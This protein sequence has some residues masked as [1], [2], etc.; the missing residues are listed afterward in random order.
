[1]ALDDTTAAARSEQVALWRA[2]GDTEKLLAFRDLCA[3]V[4]A[5]AR[6]GILLEH[7]A[8]DEVDVLRQLATR[9]FGPE[10]AAAAFGPAG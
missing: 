9:R 3:S 7:P 5:L 8:A 1:V 6:T 2:M 4:D 10:L